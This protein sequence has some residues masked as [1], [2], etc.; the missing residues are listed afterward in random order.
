[1]WTPKRVILFVCGFMTL[2]V[3]YFIYARYLGGINGLPP[4]P[5]I[6]WPRPGEEDK[7]FPPIARRLP[8][9]VQKLKVAFGPQCKE[10]KRPFKIEV[11]SKSLV[12]AFDEFQI[13]ESTGEVKVTPLS[14]AVFKKDKG[15]DGVEEINTI[16][17]KIAYLRFEKPIRTL[18][19]MG[20]HKIV[21]GRISGNVR[22]RNNRLTK[23]QNDD[24]VMEVPV[25]TL[26][27]DQMRNQI[28]T[29]EFVRIYD[30]QS[31]PKPHTIDG[32]HMIVDLTV[33][34]SM[35]KPTVKKENDT[36]HGITGV[37]RFSLKG[38]VTM[39]LYVDGDSGFLGSSK[40]K[41]EKSAPKPRKKSHVQIKTHGPFIYDMREDVAEFHIPENKGGLLGQPEFVTVTRTSTTQ[42]ADQDHLQ[43]E[44]LVLEFLS[45][46]E[47]KEQ[48]QQEA[49]RS[50]NLDIETVTATGAGP[51]S[52]VLVSNTEDLQAQGN[53]L[54]YHA[55]EERTVL[56]GPN[57]DV[58]KE[59]NR[60]TS[61]ELRLFKKDYGQ[62]IYAVGPGR[63]LL[64]KKENS[65]RGP[66]SATWNKTLT[67]TRN[68][69]GLDV[70]HLIGDASFEDI[71]SRQ[72]LRGD[73]I[74]LWLEPKSKE[75]K[76]I[77]KTTEDEESYRPQ[78]VVAIGNVQARTG[79]INIYDT[80]RFEIVFQDPPEGV[81]KGEKV[82]KAEPTED[83]VPI[84]NLPPENEKPI[85]VSKVK[86]LDSKVTLPDAKGPTDPKKEKKTR[87][88]IFLRARTVEAFVYRLEGK[89]DLNRM[90]AEGSVRVQQAPEKQGEKGVDIRGDK[91][92]LQ[93]FTE[94]NILIVTSDTDDLARLI[95]GEMTILG[96]EVKIDQVLNQA[97]VFG[98]GAMTIDSK[99]DF[100]GRP[101]KNPVP[102]T[103]HW[104][105]SMFFDGISATFYGEIQADQNS[106]LLTCETLRVVFD[107]PISLKEGGRGAKDSKVHH[108]LCEKAVQVEDTVQEKGKFIKSNRLRGTVVSYDNKAGI[109]NAKGPGT[110]RNIQLTVPKKK[111]R[112]K[113][114]EVLKM[115]YV[116]FQRKMYGNDK[117]S[118][119]KFYSNV[120]VLYMPV[121]DR[122][123]EPD[124]GKIL[125]A[126]QLPEDAMYLRCDL[127]EVYQRPR[128]QGN[129]TQEMEA[130]GRVSV[131][132]REFF[133]TSDKVTYN[134][135]KDQ[136]IFEAAPGS[137]AVL[138]KVP[139]N[140][141]PRETIR[142]EKIIYSRRT[143]Q[144]VADRVS[145]IG[146]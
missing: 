69:E 123:V 80:S 33:D 139:A 79:D 115:T 24:L 37:K 75:S 141:G 93:H 43:S 4:L 72:S 60:I 27:Y 103:I 53:Y 78:R 22:I 125:G 138:Y 77:Q 74:T 55:K 31:K 49:G 59:G 32:K 135:E 65:S 39:N 48:K 85:V 105:K 140:G 112:L 6:Y 23:T 64:D 117:S 137:E 40:R 87:N 90:M 132:A 92:N 56:K 124:M 109:V 129:P 34:R 28:W 143:G 95:M 100:Q 122:F 13:V 20:R 8:L 97:M 130:R 36:V 126:R 29:E 131:R 94:G 145:E 44:H 98:D 116:Q 41:K 11:K 62:D 5:E 127:L 136:I 67:T 50:L 68:K 107:N 1:M 113:N 110:V 82:A 86:P 106:S 83:V 101:L 71:E 21:A 12:L 7:E 35:P 66:I 134:E 16:Q 70:I 104:K 9:L 73:D 19:D 10:A 17:G 99:T 57:V 61:R 144:H 51:R 45:K 25:G 52:V 121:K 81:L 142:S 18:S 146:R 114:Q 38:W 118:T 15:P 3:G 26:F 119:V 120:R 89:T 30:Y 133:G 111:E 54:F 102:M 96:P 2:L 88:P 76:K 47:Q 63:L 42:P 128:Q 84:V 91:L 14:V 46:D 108:L 58:E